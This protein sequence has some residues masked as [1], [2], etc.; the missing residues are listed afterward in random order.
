MNI[1][2]VLIAF[3]KLLR[4]FQG[5]AD[6]AEV[7]KDEL[8]EWDRAGQKDRG[9]A[10]PLPAAKVAETRPL[11]GI[12]IPHRDRKSLRRTEPIK[13][14]AWIK[15]SK[16]C[17]MASP[18]PPPPLAAEGSLQLM[19]PERGWR[20]LNIDSPAAERWGGGEVGRWREERGEGVFSS[21]HAV[22]YAQARW[23]RGALLVGI[24]VSCR[25]GRDRRS[26]FQICLKIPSLPTLVYDS[27]SV[28]FFF[29][30][31]VEACWH[32]GSFAAF[33]NRGGNCLWCFSLPFKQLKLKTHI[34][35][36]EM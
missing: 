13:I 33:L 10:V 24:W 12:S 19:H 30:Y 1:L 11:Q 7:K 26:L 27:C 22:D 36:S 8:V 21:A 17:Q 28:L 3:K 5:L 4:L 16:A 25:I 2:R 29:Y 35:A 32:V 14:W 18:T 6:V 9:T 34:L 20:V 23:P 15:I 31:A